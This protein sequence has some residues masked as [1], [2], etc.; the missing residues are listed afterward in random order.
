MYYIWFNLPYLPV[1]KAK[2]ITHKKFVIIKSVIYFF[3]SVFKST[4]L[5]QALIYNQNDLQ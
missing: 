3:I 4:L 2:N 5:F 1:K